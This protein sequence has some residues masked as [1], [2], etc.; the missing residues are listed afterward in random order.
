MPLKITSKSPEHWANNRYSKHSNEEDLPPRT[1]NLAVMTERADNGQ[2]SFLPTPC[3][4]PTRSIPEP[5]KGISDRGISSNPLRTSISRKSLKEI[6]NDNS[7]L[8][9]Q[10]RV[11]VLPG[12]QNIKVI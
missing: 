12:K 9:V 3:L 11:S 10:K 7:N 5:F 4:C 8:E 1:G 2:R 6:P